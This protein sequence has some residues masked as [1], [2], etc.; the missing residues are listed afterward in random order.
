MKSYA[1]VDQVLEKSEVTT[2][3]AEQILSERQTG[4]FGAFGILHL[5]PI[6]KSQY[7]KNMNQADHLV[8]R[9]FVIKGKGHIAKFC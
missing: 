7:D 6:S 8:I 4:I 9:N 1:T 2:A 3:N 5:T